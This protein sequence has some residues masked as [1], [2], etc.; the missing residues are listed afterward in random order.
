MVFPYLR[1]LMVF[2]IFIRGCHG[3]HLCAAAH[4]LP[5][6]QHTSLLP[7]RE[8]TM[9]SDPD[10]DGSG[11]RHHVPVRDGA[12]RRDHAEAPPRDCGGGVSESSP[13]PQP[14]AVAFKPGDVFN[15]LSAGA[16]DIESL[17][18]CRGHPV[19]A[20]TPSLGIIG[21]YGGHLVVDMPGSRDRELR[22][23]R[24]DIVTIAPPP[25]DASIV[26]YPRRA[27]DDWRGRVPAY[28]VRRVSRELL[29]AVEEELACGCPA[30]PL[31][32]L[33]KLFLVDGV[34]HTAVWYL[35]PPPDKAWEEAHAGY[36]VVPLARCSTG[37]AGEGDAV[38]HIPGAIRRDGVA[39]SVVRSYSRANY[40][41]VKKWTKT[42]IVGT[43]TDA[44]R[45]L[46]LSRLVTELEAGTH[47]VSD[48]PQAAAFSPLEA[49]YL[50][51]ASDEAPAT[52][53]SAM[54]MEAGT[55]LASDEPQVAAA[56]SPLEA[57]CLPVASDEAAVDVPRP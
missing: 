28:E 56:F 20:I 52:A 39:V 18:G 8:P 42:C 53:D 48:E 27:D 35:P 44:A 33:G 38:A 47:F 4:N 17:M 31:H 10:D 3:A 24:W 41:T 19:L 36:I 5:C 29:D 54:P 26:R 51:A 34:W 40:Y 21:S 12:G 50:P 6:P 43:V 46:A 25:D 30:D 32:A 9:M 45:T 57:T 37:S 13:T 14:A 22:L 23:K 11:E 2:Q 16:S 7:E 1:T 15:A 55:S 49:T